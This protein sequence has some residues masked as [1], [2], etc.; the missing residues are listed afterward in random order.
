MKPEL[1]AYSENAFPSLCDRFREKNLSNGRRVIQL[2]HGSGFCYPLYYYIPSFSKDLKFLVYHKAEAGEVQLHRLDLGSGESLQLT[3][4]VARKTGW[5]HWD[6]EAGQGILDHRSVLNVA[7]GDI[8]T[9]DG[10][11]GNEV[12]SINIDSFEQQALF[13]LPEGY[14]AGGQNCVSPDGTTFVYILNPVGSKY[15]EPSQDMP[16]KV[17]AY[18]FTSGAHQVL[19]EVDFHIHHVIPYDNRHFIGCHTANGCGL[20]MTSMDEPGYTVLRAGD[21]GLKVSV[22]DEDIGGHACHYLCTE[23]GIT[24]EVIPFDMKAPKGDKSQPV[25]VVSGGFH[26]GLYNPFS[27]SRF[28][29]PLPDFFSGTHMGWDPQGRRWFWEIMPSWDEASANQLVYLR[30]IEP[31]GEAEFFLLTPKWMNYGSKQ[32]SHHHPQ[33]TPD[34]DWLLFVAGDPET[35]TNHLHLLDISDVPETE[36]IGTHLLSPTGQNDIGQ[37]KF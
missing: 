27:R 20:F 37:F 15:L 24:Y 3:S 34:P 14:Y 28:E 35:E 30:R 18:D 2:T 31:S 9:F 4:G 29:F 22:D 6:D 10:E 7:T 11:Q 12:R 16:S 23:L 33:V 13:T 1:Y 17:V 32:K 21:P 25:K 26:S 19:C 8:L 36:G 5:D